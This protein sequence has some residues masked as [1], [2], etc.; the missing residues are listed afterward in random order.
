[1]KYI[2]TIFILGIF[3]FFLL[4]FHKEPALAVSCNPPV[5]GNLTISSDCAFSGTVDG[6]D[7]GTGAANTAVLSVSS[8]ILTINPG[9]TISVGSLNMTGGSVALSGVIKIGTPLWMTDADSDG[10]PAATTQ[11]AQAS[12][13]TNG[14]RRNL[15]TSLSTIDTND[16]QACADGANPTGACN[17]CQTGGIVNQSSSEDLFSECAAGTASTVLNSASGISCTAKCAQYAAT[18][19]FCNGSGACATQT[20]VSIGTE[21]GT[22]GM[23]YGESNCLPEGDPCCRTFAGNCSTLMTYQTPNGCTTPPGKTTHCKCQ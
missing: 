8:G 16:S 7:S 19:G 11:Y 4:F 12:A 6:V 14:R 22:N 5:G 9:Q 15:M 10:Y 13:P 1:M 17:K 20:C 23:Y 21:T 18:S 3:Q 2:K